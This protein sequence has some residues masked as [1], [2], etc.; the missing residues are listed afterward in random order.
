MIEFEKVINATQHQRLLDSFCDA[1]GVA[2]AIIDLKGNILV[3]ARWQKICTDFHRV[4]PA[5]CERCTESDINLANRLEE[6]ER[7][8]LL[9]GAATACAMRPL[10]SSSTESMWRTRSSVSFCL[11]CQTWMHSVRRPASSAS[12]RRST[13]KLSLWCPS[14]LRTGCRA[15]RLSHNLRGD[16]R[17]HGRRV[18][19]QAE[20]RTTVVTSC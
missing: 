17:Q 18:R 5:S 1:V 19:S 14:F 11:K 6:G 10:Q 16:R 3:G 12:T 20:H 2:A 9:P 15:S 7:Y 8:S 4:N 13:S